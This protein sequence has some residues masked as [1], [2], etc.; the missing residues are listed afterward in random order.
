MCGR[1]SATLC[2]HTSQVWGI[3]AVPTQ[4]HT[5][6][7]RRKGG[8]DQNGGQREVAVCVKSRVERERERYYLQ[9][10]PSPP[11]TAHSPEPIA[12]PLARV[13]AAVETQPS[14]PI[15]KQTRCGGVSGPSH[16][17]T[18][19]SAARQTSLTP[20]N[21]CSFINSKCNVLGS[22]DEVRCGV[23]DLR[24]EAFGNGLDMDH[25]DI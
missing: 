7:L 22:Q 15:C 17:S 18:R 9:R 4:Q 5:F 10:Q 3:G 24:R 19:M 13:C 14:A 8:V 20:R 6:C 11:H 2:V 25:G 16:T 21:S 23:V 12:S 1:F